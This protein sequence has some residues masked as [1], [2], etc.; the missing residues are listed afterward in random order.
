MLI[1]KI[2]QYVCDTCGG[3]ITTIDR[4]NGTTPFFMDCRVTA[5][6]PG[7]MRSAMYRVEQSLTPDYEWVAP[8]NAVR[9]REMREH[10]AMGGLMIRPIAP[11]E[12]TAT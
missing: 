10:V 6:C 8:T 9:R 4:D 1:G 7:A 12:K 2:N 3:V 11:D 5:G